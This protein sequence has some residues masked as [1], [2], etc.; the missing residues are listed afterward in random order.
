[1]NGFFLFKDVFEGEYRPV[2]AGHLPIMA[3]PHCTDAAF[4]QPCTWHLCMD[5]DLRLTHRRDMIQF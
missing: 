5:K 1:M 2:P 4:S 3:I